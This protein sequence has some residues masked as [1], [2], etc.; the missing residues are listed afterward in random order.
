MM[1]TEA[2]ILTVEEMYVAD[3]W[4]MSQGVSGLTLMENAG[5]AVAK[6]LVQRFDRT[7]VAVLCGP[8]NNGG[9]GF[10]VARHLATAGWAVNLYLLG[11]R[12]NLKGDAAEMAHRWNGAIHPL[13][14]DALRGCGLVVDALFGAGLSKPLDGVPLELSRVSKDLEIPVVSIDV[15]SGVDGN[16][17]EDTGGAF[18]AALTISFFRQKPGHLIFPGRALCGELLLSQIGID[19]KALG[20]IKP[21]HAEN[22][23]GN[24]LDAF[25]WPTLQGHKY[26]RG[27][28]VVVSG[29]MSS[30]GAARLGARAALRVG[31][32]LVTVASP[33]S[34]MM[35]NAA[36][37]TSIM[38]AKLEDSNA[39]AKLLE[40]KRHNA[41]LIGPG[42][43]VGSKTRDLV[44]TILLS[45][46]ATVL[47]AD[48]LT[49][50]EETPRD[51]FVAIQ[52]YFA[53]PVVLTPHEGEFKRLFPNLTGNK[54]Y[55]AKEAAKLSGA[56]IVLKGPDT[57]IASPDGRT[58]INANGVPELATAGSGD[59]LAGLVTGLQAQQM[60]A[61]E[62]ACAAVWIHAEAAQL[63]GPGLIAE[64]LTEEV[65]EV[66]WALKEMTN[67]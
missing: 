59:V 66:L 6:A 54:L 3:R 57:L 30:T 47:D 43:G 21:M 18:Q 39:M 36:H 16:T 40:D 37:L 24:W 41:V 19:D 48:A 17:G 60:P 14:G 23:P 50:F 46:A 1:S 34:A 32:G 38:L 45:G 26:T 2:E 5:E 64:D 63:F 7:G 61:F 31:A 4:A 12:E 65:P 9:D 53:G 15:P 56:I 13:N 51:L 55:R 42:A 8:G 49:S 29:A 28:A 58:A 67:D 52:S 33:P 22:L 44:N 27:H 20:D 25:P 11:N 35:T 62:A 10:V